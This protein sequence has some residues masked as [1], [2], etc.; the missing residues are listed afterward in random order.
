MMMI[1]LL[2]GITFAVMRHNNP[3]QLGSPGRIVKIDESLEENISLNCARAMGE[4]EAATKEI[5]QLDAAMLLPVTRQW[6]SR[7]NNMV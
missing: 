2:T 6:F 7:N 5:Q 1:P 3:V 4:Y